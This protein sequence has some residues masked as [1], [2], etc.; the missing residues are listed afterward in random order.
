M[1]NNK[2]PGPDDIPSELIPALEEV[3]IKEVTKQYLRH[4]RDLDR[5]EEVYLHCDS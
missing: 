2:A 1:K 3:G 5:Y 4:R